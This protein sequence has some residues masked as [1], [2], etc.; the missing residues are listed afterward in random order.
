MDIFEFILVLVTVIVGLGIA[1]LLG[2]VVRILRHE[3]KPGRLHSLWIWMIFEMQVQWLWSSWALRDRGEWLFPEFI[4]LLALPVVLYM[5][6]AVLFPSTDTSDDLDAHFFRHRKPFFLL[7]MACI[8]LYSVNHRFLE[9]GDFGG[10]ADAIRVAL[11][12][13]LGILMN[14]SHRGVHWALGLS[15]LGVQFWWVYYFGFAI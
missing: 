9:G 4:L 14:T 1:E 5:I 13:S 7:L 15:L 10:L 11:F 3:L 12:I 2:G 6:A 8:I